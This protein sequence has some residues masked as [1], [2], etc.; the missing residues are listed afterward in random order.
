MCLV[1]NKVDRLIL[2]LRLTPGEAY[3]RIKSI[4]AHVNMIVSSFQSGGCRGPPSPALRLDRWIDCRALGGHLPP[5]LEAKQ[6][7]C[8]RC[9]E[10][11]ISEAD[12]VLAYEDA[13]AA[14]GGHEAREESE[15]EEEGQDVFA[16]ERGN[17]AFGSAHDGWAFHI[18]QFA[19]LY[20][21]ERCQSSSYSP[22]SCLPA[23]RSPPCC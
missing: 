17:V 13:K 1:V 15:E 8:A 9:A 10:R 20:A 6:T 5:G 16:P 23:L 4:I 18:P 2:E 7:C 12:S 21:G 19:K 22:P 14:A 3:E 11:F